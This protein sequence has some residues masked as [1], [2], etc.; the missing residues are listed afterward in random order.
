MLR[1]AVVGWEA[2]CT[3]PSREDTDSLHVPR[4]VAERH[5]S[6]GE[7]VLEKQS[8]R[9]GDLTRDLFKEKNNRFPGYLIGNR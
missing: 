8:R 5:L 6:R 1:L 7:E 9:E 3:S 4:D 2:T